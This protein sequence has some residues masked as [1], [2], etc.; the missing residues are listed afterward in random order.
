M[1]ANLVQSSKIHA[2]GPTRAFLL[3]DEKPS[4]AVER[5]DDVHSH[6]LG[7][8]PRERHVAGAVE[9]I[10]NYLENKGFLHV[11]DPGL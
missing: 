2:L 5:L 11:V 8:A 3:G 4:G 1:D 7:V 9:Q 6:I 10:L